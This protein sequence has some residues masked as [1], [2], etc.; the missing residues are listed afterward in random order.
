MS[1]LV[2]MAVGLSM[3]P[4]VTAA[5]AGPMGV[6]RPGEHQSEAAAHSP[7]V[8][9]EAASRPKAVR[10]TTTKRR[11]VSRSTTTTTTTATSTVPVS[12]T[13]VSTTTFPITIP[14]TVVTSTSR[15]PSFA[16]ARAIMSVTVPRDASVTIPIALNLEPGFVGPVLLSATVPA[17]VTITFD[18]NPARDNAVLTLTVRGGEGV[19]PIITIVGSSGGQTRTMALAVLVPAPVVAVVP[20]PVVGAGFALGVAQPSVGLVRDGAIGSYLITIARDDNFTGPVAMSVV[21][22]IPDGV[23]VSFSA[24]PTS[25]PDISMFVRATGR[26]STGSL[27]ITVLGSGSAGSV[28]ITVVVRVV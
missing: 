1:A 12:T 2:A 7:N 3:V 11:G 13:T 22:A 21:S 10:R 18:P 17:G 24:N 4:G 28:S 19:L 26:A 16:F 25:G 6:R 14:T 5:E 20:S 27:P 8:T 23:V 9:A 15:P